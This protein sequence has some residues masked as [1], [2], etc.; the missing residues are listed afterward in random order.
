[1][2]LIELSL[3]KLNEHASAYLV[4]ITKSKH[5]TVETKR[6]AHR[7]INNRDRNDVT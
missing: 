5:F 4:F 2:N 7:V 1:M 3:V 6:L